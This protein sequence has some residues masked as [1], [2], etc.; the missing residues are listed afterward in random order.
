VAQGKYTDTPQLR[1]AIKRELI[2]REVMIQEANKQGVGTRA[3]VKAALDNARQ[4]ILINAMLADFVK[5]NPN[6]EA[7][8]RAEYERE[9]AG[10][11]DK[12]YHARHILVAT[13]EE[14]KA[15]IA[16]L[17]AGAKFDEL[18]KAISKDGSAA[19]GGDLDWANPARYVPEFGMALSAMSKGAVSETPVRTKFGYHVIKVDDIRPTKHKSYEEER[20]AISDSMHQR[21]LAAFREEL[22]KKAVIK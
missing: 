8:V 14:A 21:K 1:E 17:K 2:I 22:M 7:D 12:D 5:K 18:A 19:N 16:K 4:S 15:A 20:Q 9:K 6:K 13:E 11:S 3:D 10:M